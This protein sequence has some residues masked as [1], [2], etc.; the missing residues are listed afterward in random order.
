MKITHINPDNL[1]K[2]PVFSQAVL[3]EVGTVR[4]CP[5]TYPGQTTVTGTP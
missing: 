5:S 1:Y 2:I 3:A 4:R